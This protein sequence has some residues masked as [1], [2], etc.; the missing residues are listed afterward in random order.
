MWGRIRKWQPV[1]NEFSANSSTAVCF[2]DHAADSRRH[3]E[4]GYVAPDLLPDRASVADKLDPNWDQ[5]APYLER[6]W[7]FDFL[8][9]SLIRSIIS[10]VG[11]KAGVSAI[12]WKYGVC[13]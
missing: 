3:I 6:A 9:P 2:D 10:A 5:N 7:R 11:Q 13:L 4:A 1:G 8:S 12:Y